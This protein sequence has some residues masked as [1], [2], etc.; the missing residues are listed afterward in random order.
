MSRPTL[1]ML[2]ALVVGL[3]A[4]IRPVAATPGASPA[5]LIGL[6]APMSGPLAKQGQDLEAAVRMALAEDAASGK[7][8]SIGLRVADDKGDPREG[9]LAARQL[10]ASGVV[11]VVGPWNSG[12]TLPVTAEVYGPAGLAVLTMS[13]NPRIT[14]RG[15][16]QVFRVIGR[17]DRQGRIAATEALK[18]GC[19]S[20]VVLDNRAAYGKGLADAFA[21]AF[22]AGGGTV[23]LR[24]SVTSGDTDHS[25][26]LARIRSLHP[27]L[28]YLGSEYQDAGPLARQW[29]KLG[30]G[31]TRLFAGDAVRDPLFIRLAGAS[32]AEGTLVTFPEPTDPRFE[33]RLRARG[34]E[35]GAFSGHAYD[36]ARLLIHAIRKAGPGAT[37]QAVARHVGTVSGFRGVTGR[38]DFDPRGDLNRS[39]F[40]LWQVREG[41]FQVLR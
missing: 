13:T 37:R 32:A 38:I 35:P 4:L 16:R 10:L 3:G 17:D 8:P 5:I 1:V 9:V 29:R 22:A 31:K 25:P 18:L 24:E 28:L 21:R 15:L 20:A 30:G 27:D 12:V 34:R 19:R 36:A 26:L 14:E 33:E 39:G 41:R 11:G 6:Q 23:R 7:Q 2:A 40:M